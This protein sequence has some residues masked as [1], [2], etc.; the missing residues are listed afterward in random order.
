MINANEAKKISE[1]RFNRLLHAAE[2]E[3]YDAAM[4]GLHETKLVRENPYS[5]SL[6]NTLKELGYTIED[7]ND[8]VYWYLTIKW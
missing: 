3:I 6:A 5:F 7:Y 8:S 4:R 2:R 1:D